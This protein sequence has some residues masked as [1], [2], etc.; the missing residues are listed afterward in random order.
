AAKRAYLLEA[1]HAVARQDGRASISRLSVAT[2]MTRK[3]V[4]AL[5]TVSQ[6]TMDAGTRR[7]GQQRALR[8]LRGWLTDPRFQS[9]SGRPSELKYRGAEMSFTHLVKLYG[10]DVTPK[11]VL[12]ELERIEVVDSGNTDVLRVRLSRRRGN[13][14]MNYKLS[15][16][17]RMFEDFAFAVIQSNSSQN[18]PSFFGF[19]ESVI[20]STHDAAYFMRRF[21]RRAVAFLDDFQQWSVGRKPSKAGSRQG[22]DATRVGLGVYLLRSDLRS[23][24]DVS[25]KSSAS[26][27]TRHNRERPNRFPR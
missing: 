26:L 4:S 14:E 17:A 11:S 22:D 2:G 12:R 3:E 18:P 27:G 20:S 7:S 10:G 15:D 6:K 13:I 21:S 16:L 25:G 19:R 5:L 1:M 9:R 23:A 8:V 24:D